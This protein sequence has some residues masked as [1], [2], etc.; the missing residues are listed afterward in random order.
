MR[1][2]LFVEGSSA[3]PGRATL[4]HA[5]N[6]ILESAGLRSFDRYYP[7]SKTHLVAMDPSKPKMSGAAEG[8]DDYV[9]RM[10]QRDS[11]DAVV[12]A[13]DLAPPWDTSAPG[14]RWQETLS[15][16]DNIQKRKRIPDPFLSWASGR[17]MELKARKNPSARTALPKLEKGSIWPVCMEPEF[18]SL[19]ISDEKALKRAVGLSGVQARNWPSRKINQNK[20]FLAEAIVAASQD[21][22]KRIRGDWRTNQYGWCEYLVKQL[23]AESYWASHQVVLR[24]REILS[25]DRSL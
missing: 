23:A 7:I 12:V 10:H 16:Y 15:I 20:R 22:K 4:D 18:E 21:I 19:L 8:F 1:V 5:W 24:L 2:A 9:R 3:P 11:F 6:S 13:W 14:C 25:Q 17:Y